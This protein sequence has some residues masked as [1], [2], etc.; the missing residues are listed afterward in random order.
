MGQSQDASKAFTNSGT[1][2][3]LCD[4]LTGHGHSVT[5]S[6][7]S[8]ELMIMLVSRFLEIFLELATSKI[9]IKCTG[10]HDGGN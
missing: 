5:S 10:N 3:R 7:M 8:M 6:L 9:R 4:N 1:L 2:R